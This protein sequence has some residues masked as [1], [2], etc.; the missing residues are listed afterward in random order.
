MLC[1]ELSFRDRTYTVIHPSVDLVDA[2][3][4][5]QHRNVD[6][7]Q[8]LQKSELFQYTA[9]IYLTLC[10]DEVV[11]N[12]IKLNKC[13]HQQSDRLQIRT[14]C[15]FVHLEF[16]GLYFIHYV[17]SKEINY[18]SNISSNH[19]NSNFRLPKQIATVYWVDSDI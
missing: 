6:A 3:F 19:V 1:I 17:N 8:S 16:S 14:G 12:A 2:S 9:T 4:N 7:P 13:E 10:N 15:K 11:L 18:T 5:M